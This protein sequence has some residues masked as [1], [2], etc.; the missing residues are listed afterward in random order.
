MIQPSVW[1]S[2]ELFDKVIDEEATKF[3]PVPRAD[4]W[5][6]LRLPLATWLVRRH[7][8]RV[9][10]FHP[11]HR[12]TP[13]DIRDLMYLRVT[14]AWLLNQSTMTFSQRLIYLDAEWHKDGLPNLHGKWC[15]FSF[16]LAKDRVVELTRKGERGTVRTASK[17]FETWR[18]RHNRLAQENTRPHTALLPCE[19]ILP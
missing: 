14:V 9:Q 17:A 10:R 16:F 5:D 19:Q 1:W 12:S 2:Q 11:E 6:Y 15:G 8:L 13:E 7:S 3:R 4:M 18:D